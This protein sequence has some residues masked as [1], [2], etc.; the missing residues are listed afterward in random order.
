MTRNS[1]NLILTLVWFCVFSAAGLHAEAFTTGQVVY[2]SPTGAS[3]DWHSGCTV[4]EGR[5]NN[6]YQV[7]CDGTT[8]WINRDHIRTT[9][10][11]AAPDPMHPGQML[12]PVITPP[13]ARGAGAAETAPAARKPA[14][15]VATGRGGNTAKTAQVGIISPE[16]V[17]SR[18]AQDNADAA[19]AILKPGKY[20]CYASG[21][22]TFSDLF[23]DSAD[24]YHVEPGGR[25]SYSY[26]RGA[27]TF[28]SGPYAGAYSRMVDGKT[29]GV[30]AKG[31]TNLGTQC[32][33]EGK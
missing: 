3:N 5:S 20:A 2:A 13:S 22:Y 8:W 30:S 10:P 9:A 15:A 29:I 24:A 18:I 11:V 33:Y 23:I 17:H 26:S 28:S 25:G 31:N 4:A 14:T 6:S 21:R 7:S 16:E 1:N 12:V 19:N 27:L 32:E